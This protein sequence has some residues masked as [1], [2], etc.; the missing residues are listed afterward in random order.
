MLKIIRKP[1]KR[2]KPGKQRIIILTLILV[3]V[4]FKVL[5]YILQHPHCLKDIY[6]CYFRHIV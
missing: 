2:N 1:T 5:Y 3:T 4:I 6:D